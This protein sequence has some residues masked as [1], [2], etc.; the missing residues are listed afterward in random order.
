MNF[1]KLYKITDEDG[2]H[3]FLSN[4]I[5]EAYHDYCYGEHGLDFPSATFEGIEYIETDIPVTY[6]PQTL[7]KTNQ[8]TLLEVVWI[9]DKDMHHTNYIAADIDDFF[10][11]IKSDNVNNWRCCD[12]KT[13]I[14]RFDS[15]KIKF[16]NVIMIIKNEKDIKILDSI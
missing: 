10:D 6:L 3:Y 1:P 13:R 12:G 8:T 14:E 2:E 9:D 7:E 15:V 5:D 16:K 4:S 11:V